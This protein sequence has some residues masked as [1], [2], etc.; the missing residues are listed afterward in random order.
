M[1]RWLSLAVRAGLAG[2]VLWALGR[3]VDWSAVG[4]T[5]A[6]AEG[7]W[8]AAGFALVPLNTG[9]EAY[10]W[11]RLVR[12][13]APGVPLAASVRAVLAGYPLGLIG[14]GRLGDLAGR[15]Y[16]LRQVNAWL[17]G[18]LTLA[19]RTATVV[20]CL[21]GGLAVAA[22][23]AWGPGGSPA[24][25]AVWLIGLA[26]AAT[27]TAIVL[28]P[29]VLSRLLQRWL[30]AGR[31]AGLR[32][33]LDGLATLPHRET[34][35]LLALSAVRYSVFTTQLTSFVVACAPGTPFAQGFRGAV[36]TYFVK[37]AVPPI[38]LGELGV[39]EAV[40]T[41]A[42]AHFGVAAAAAVGGG[43]LVFGSNVLIPAA[44]GLPYLLGRHRAP[45]AP[46]TAT[47]AGA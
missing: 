38:T 23:L 21:W 19:E 5:L 13:G 30:P 3:A 25:R 39:R 29:G 18:A 8:L 47:E 37:S 33:G 4:A 32:R 10:R 34:T 22:P 42:M 11:H 1:P 28:R 31:L 16:Y 12:V 7:A 43:L 15:A 26:W 2:L 36:L 6:A 46:I 14:P 35:V 45:V 44:A 27:S 40:A 17:V 24:W 41:F 20:W 9:L